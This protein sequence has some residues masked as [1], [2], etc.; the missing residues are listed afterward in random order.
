M[1]SRS[2]LINR[3]DYIELQ[4]DVA[5]LREINRL[6]VDEVLAWRIADDACKVCG[7]IARAGRGDLA[8]EI[9]RAS[10]R[11]DRVINIEGK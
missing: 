1:A 4:G 6:L 3:D 11:V 8:V 9:S 2:I 5:S 10:R 7:L